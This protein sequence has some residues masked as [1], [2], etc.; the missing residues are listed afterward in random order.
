MNAVAPLQFRQEKFNPKQS[1][2][3]PSL[4]SFP[5]PAKP[6]GFHP[7]IRPPMRMGAPPK[8]ESTPAG[9]SRNSNYAPPDPS[10]F[11]KQRFP[12]ELTTLELASLEEDL[13][14]A[15]NNYDRLVDEINRRFADDEDTRNKKLKSAKDG[16]Q[17]K[18]SQ[19]R[20]RRGVTLRMRKSDQAE[21]RRTQEGSM[22][23]PVPPVPAM[24]FSP[25][26]KPA[27]GSKSS[28]AV[29]APP[30]PDFRS[31]VPSY[32]A[33]VE[34]YGQRQPAH[35]SPYSQ[36]VAPPRSLPSMR[37][38]TVA[39]SSQPPSNKKRRSEEEEHSSPR[40]NGPTQTPRSP[41]LTNPQT[42]TVSA[43]GLQMMEM[44][45]EDAATKY[46]TKKQVGGAAPGS[47]GKGT[48]DVIV[49][50]DSDS[51]TD[52]EPTRPAPIPRSA[53]EVLAPSIEK[54]DDKMEDVTEEGA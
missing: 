42:R 1:N 48:K 51:E 25:V 9:P 37:V 13:Q 33:H 41:W 28:P 52:N 35:V 29:A 17:T 40:P 26:N 46:K 45:S 12:S 20:K 15:S 49:L 4:G 24:S 3:V 53:P 8:P 32:L 18:K 5:P 10:D 34:P 16:F 50:T 23:V 2:P 54:D 38:P 47:S 27:S 31:S 39:S 22:V 19:I 11:G 7:A 30:P 21:R 44:R 43:P 36:E 6:E 14:E